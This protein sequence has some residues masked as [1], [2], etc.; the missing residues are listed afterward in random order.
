MTERRRDEVSFSAL[1]Q[2]PALQYWNDLVN[3]SVTLWNEQ[4]RRWVGAWQRVA[5]QQETPEQW[6]EDVSQLWRGWIST[7]T[8]FSAFPLEWSVR[9][10]M[11]VPNLVFMV[12]DVAQTTPSQSAFTNITAEGLVVGATALSR[13]GGR[14]RVPA[15]KV[16][17]DLLDR[18]NR[19]Q[20]TLVNLAS[21]P[22]AKENKLVPGLY[23]G[24]AYA[25]E[26]PSMRPLALIYLY[27]DG[28][29]EQP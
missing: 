20:V 15:D 18:G 8:G 25:Y 6:M 10:F 29:T 19:V 27:V 4:I 28:H 17:V 2:G 9:R 26:R 13:V 22:G 1:G 24:V 14:E 16:Q 7:M 12:D 3:V 5:T 21:R 23:L 11:N